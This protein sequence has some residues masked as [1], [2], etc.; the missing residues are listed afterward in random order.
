MRVGSFPVKTN[1]VVSL[2]ILLAINIVGAGHAY[3]QVA[4]ATLSGTITDASHAGIPKADVSITAVATTVTRKVTTDSAGFYIAPNLSPGVY[5]VIVT[6]TGF[7]TETRKGVTLTVGAQQILDIGMHIGQITQSVQVTE[8]APQVELVSSAISAEVNSTTVR[9]LPLNGRSWTDLAALQPGVTSIETQP[10]FTVGADRG[11]RGFGSQI[12]ITGARPQMNN[13]RLDGL[14]MNGY[15]NSGPGSVLGGQLGV[16]AVQEFSVLTTN[17]S[18]E[19]GRTAGGVINAITKSGT[20]QIHGTAYEFL[21]N[22]A[23]DARN[24]FDIGNAPPP[25]K[26]NQFGASIG[27]PILKGRTFFFAD[28]EGIRQ[29]K[30][31]SV[32]AT[33]PSPNARLGILSG[34]AAANQTVGTA[35]AEPNGATGHWLSTQAA[36]CVD[37]SAVKYLTFYPLPNTG[38]LING[39]D[40][41]FFTFA[42]SQKVTENFVTGKIDHKFSDKDSISGTILWDKTPFS[43]AD[44]LNNVLLGNLSLDQTDVIEWT[45]V[46]KPT[47]VNSIRGGYNRQKANVDYSV[48]PINPAASDLTLGANTG[49]YASQVQIGGLP[50]FTGGM[51]GN[52]TYFYRWNSFQG[53]D[54]A[55]FTHGA[56][57]I[58][59][60]GG[61]E[62]MQNNALGLSNPN[63]LFIFGSFQSFLT[64]HPNKFNS[65]LA[66]TLRT[67]GYRQTLFGAYI[68]DDWRVLPN[69]TLNLGV[70]YETVTVEKELKNQLSS[71]ATITSPLP[72]CGVQVSGC[73]SAGPLYSNPTHRDFQPRVGFAWDPFHNGKTAVRGGFGLFDNLPLMYEFTG[74]EILAAPFFKIGSITDSKAP[75]GLAGRFYTGATPLLLPST[76]RGALIE[77]KMPRNYVMQWNLNI[78]RQITPS[79]T[80]LVGYVGAHGVHMPLRID[81][82]DIVMPTKTSAGY[83]WP[84][85]IGSADVINPNFGSIRGIFYAG[86]SLFHALEAGV[87][88]KM[89]HGVQFQTSFT[90]GKTIDNSSGT[91]Y[92]DQFSNSMSSL[93][94]FDKSLTRSVSDFNIGRTLVFNASWELPEAKSINAALG[95]LVNGW[96]LGGIFKVSD[97]VPFTPTFGTGGDPVGIGSSDDWAYPDRLATPGC[98]SLVNPGKPDN[99]IKTECFSVPSAPNMAFWTANCDPFPPSIQSSDP[100]APPVPATFPQCFNL[101]GNAGRNILTSPGLFNVDF[102]LFK[103]NYIKQ[104]S[105]NFNIQFRAEIFNI[106]N[107]P[108]FGPPVMPDNTDIFGSDGTLSGSAGVL[109]STVTTS[110]EI[111][112][113]LKFIW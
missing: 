6:A 92:A 108:N 102:S 36:V 110:R 12:A 96:Q 91:G 54:D 106:L 42:Q 81:D 100:T 45:H 79:I 39:G 105:E 61:V 97:G 88:K 67:R 24:F 72:I 49:R 66:E 18:A 56:H 82:I 86:D 4:G 43:T 83:L 31:V 46:F 44:G 109:S 7:A 60:G 50:L 48:S 28:Y 63:G 76:L 70:R 64:N 27:G 68:Q 53:Y 89:S 112:F 84:N 113:A 73:A 51:D 94:W 85:P 8:E 16:D 57:S 93:T 3:A 23:L 98:K 104:I 95:R 9:E 14:S 30:G 41:G 103:N 5:E 17:Y 25:F 99:Y 13:Y 15:S 74:M 26:R 90:F 87:T 75:G 65:G 58:K 20:N 37:D 32:R 21:R 38:A 62:R 1:V 107:H 101:R 47:L 77:Q 29:S 80:A 69:L 52:P 111:Q 2:F 40:A 34:Q 59:F 33:V 22:S 55:F 10:T 35:C 11:N 78:Q 71:L 19:Y